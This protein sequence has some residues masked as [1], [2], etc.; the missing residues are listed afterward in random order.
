MLGPSRG[1]LASFL[2]YRCRTH[3]NSILDKLSQQ[4]N[5]VASSNISPVFP[6]SFHKPF[7]CQA[8]LLSF[9]PHQEIPRGHQTPSNCNTLYVVDKDIFQAINDK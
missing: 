2:L 3:T 7:S 9:E 4:S 1:D 6:S 8:L 5:L